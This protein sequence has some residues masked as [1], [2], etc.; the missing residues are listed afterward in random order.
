MKHH[1]NA[2]NYCYIATG[3]DSSE[4]RLIT[5]WSSQFL[6]MLG[7]NRILMFSLD[8]IQENYSADGLFLRHSQDEHF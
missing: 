6:S 2:V 3:T 8:I 5:I 1:Q 7:I 4:T